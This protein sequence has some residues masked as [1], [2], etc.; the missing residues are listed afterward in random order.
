MFLEKIKTKL[1]KVLFPNFYIKIGDLNKEIEETNELLHAVEDNAKRIAI[2][3][4]QLQ[5]KLENQPTMADLMREN[6]GL[7]T[8]DFSNAQ[9]DGTPVHFLDLLSKDKRMQYINELHQIFQLEVWEVMCKNHIDTQGNFS[10]RKA[11]GEIQ[12]L[13][14]R[15]SVNG[16]SLL[17]NEVKKGHEEYVERSNPAN[18]DYEKDDDE[19][20]EVGEGIIIKDKV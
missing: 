18:K 8:L 20:F 15:M 2:E 11:D 16:I 6:L 13:A 17:R 7:V 9:E 19:Q 14:G 3:K 12:N 1:H 4:A 10:F 5:T